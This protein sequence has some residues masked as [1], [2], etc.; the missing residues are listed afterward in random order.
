[1]GPRWQQSS[2]WNLCTRAMK[3]IGASRTA[4]CMGLWSGVDHRWSN[5]LEAR[6]FGDCP[7]TFQS[8]PIAL[9][10]FRLTHLRRVA[11]TPSGGPHLAGLEARVH[12]SALDPASG[13]SVPNLAPLPLH[14]DAGGL[15]TS[16]QTVLIDP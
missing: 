9:P 16:I 10:G 3:P 6:V 5:T 7:P 4:C 8:F 2:W 1:M 14:G 13:S 12:A 15:P 11:S